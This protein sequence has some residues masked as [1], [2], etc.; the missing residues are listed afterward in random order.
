MAV[1]CKCGLLNP[2][3]AVVC[4]CGVALRTD[5][6]AITVAQIPRGAED[7]YGAQDP[8]PA[9]SARSSPA[10]RISPGCSW[11]QL[12]E[13]GAAQRLRAVCV[14]GDDHEEVTASALATLARAG[15]SDRVDE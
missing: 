14:C 11:S 13:F 2:A 8:G 12:G 6:D 3:G 15:R 1:R 4:D 5:V 9:S 7:S 10:G